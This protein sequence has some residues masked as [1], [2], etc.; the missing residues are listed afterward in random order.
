MD[1]IRVGVA[2]CGTIA[3][4]MHLPGLKQM[5]DLG[6]V[7]IVAV[8][9]AFPDKAE[10]AG[11]QYDVAR[12]YG[13]V[14]RMLDGVPFDLLVNLTPI[15]EHFSVTMTGLQAGRHVYTQKPMALNVADATL[16][17]EEARRQGVK[18]ASAPEH[19][20]RPPIQAI[21]RLIENNAIGN[22]AFARVVSSHDG[23][24]KHDVPRD[25][26]WFYQTG[27][28]P[29]LDLGVHGLSQITH[30]LGP[31][32]RLS[33]FSGRATSTRVH[34]ANRFKG[35]AIGVEI[36]DNSL[37]MLDF[38]NSRFSFLDATYCVEATLSPSIEIHGT[39]GTISVV[40]EGGHRDLVKIFESDTHAGRTVDVPEALPVRDLGVL[41]LVDCLRDGG[42]LLLTGERGRHLVDIM[43]QAAIAAQTGEIQA[44]T[45]RF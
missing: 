35:K 27:S 17:V 12:R 44:V 9:D 20:V 40:D 5:R 6:K 29:I 43:A 1:P 24:E 42:E 10:A 38:G 19:P 11:I 39:T 7:E 8:C 14:R 31:V 3:Q 28:S 37:L 26:S 4:V 2:G 36:D 30:I 32:K 18:L 25:S 33:C 22:V 13:D 45:T 34:T 23:P 15:P 41:H 16:L 21:K